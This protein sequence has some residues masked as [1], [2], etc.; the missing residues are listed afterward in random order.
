MHAAVSWVYAY[1]GKLL[2][3]G[4]ELT[5]TCHKASPPSWSHM[6]HY[7]V[8]LAVLQ[9]VTTFFTHHS[10]IPLYFQIFSKLGCFTYKL[11]LKIESSPS[12]L[13]AQIHSGLS[14]L[15]TTLNLNKEQI[16]STTVVL[17]GESI[18]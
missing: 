17:G 18:Q 13:H 4:T 2:I 3:V 5:V 6:E 15:G 10:E 14:S 8:P 1:T 9:Y 12:P 7:S 11:A 16:C